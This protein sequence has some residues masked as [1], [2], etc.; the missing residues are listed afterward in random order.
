M[1]RRT[2]RV[3]SA[4]PLTDGDGDRAIVVGFAGLRIAYSNVAPSPS[5]AGRKVGKAG[6]DHGGVV[7]RHR[8]PAREPHDQEAHGDAVI[9]MGRDQAAALRDAAALDDEIVALDRVRNVRGGEAGGDRGETVAFLDPELVQAAHPR[10]PG[11]EGRGDREDRIFVDHRG[12]ARGGHVDARERARPHAQVGDLLAALD[13][14]VENGD[15]GPHLEERRQQPGAQRVRH[16]ALD[17]DVRAGDDQRRH[18]RERRRRRVGRHDDRTG[19]KFRAAD[20]VDPAPVALARDRHLGAE[21]G[22]HLLGMV[23]RGLRLDH[24][25]HAARVEAGEQ[26]GRLDLR[27]GDRAS[28]RESGP[29]RA[30][31]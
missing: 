15:L 9:H 17:H 14:R 25:R 20:E 11:G 6:G 29:D 30:R 31:P 19:P 28:G 4:G 2:L 5:I 7:D 26:H 22:Q 13:A 3:R 1:A 24:G 10:R 18:D 27:R 21:M 12:R 23:A 16:D 8:F